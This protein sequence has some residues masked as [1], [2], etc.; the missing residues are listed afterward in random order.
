MEQSRFRGGEGGCSSFLRQQQM[1][2][3]T[4]SLSSRYPMFIT[5]FLQTFFCFCIQTNTKSNVFGIFCFWSSSARTQ[6]ITYFLSR[7]KYNIRVT[8]SHEVFQKNFRQSCKLNQFIS[9]VRYIF[10]TESTACIATLTTMASISVPGRTC[11]SSA[12]N[13]CM[14]WLPWMSS[15]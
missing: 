5:V 11:T 2:P 8:E 14:P 13:F 6:F 4:N 7:I 1:N 9:M 3:F 12:E 10:S 15:R